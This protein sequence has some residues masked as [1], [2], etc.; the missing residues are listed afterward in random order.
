MKLNMLQC[1]TN[2]IIVVFILSG[3]Y[4]VDLSKVMDS[5]PSIEYGYK[6]YIILVSDT[7]TDIKFY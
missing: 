7:V 1:Y 5:N 4:S 6:N 3:I 2:I